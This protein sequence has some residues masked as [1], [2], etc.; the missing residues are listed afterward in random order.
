M[1]RLVCGLDFETTGLNPLEDR[2][3]EVGAVLWDWD[4]QCPIQIF[5]ELVASGYPITPGAEKIHGIREKD[6]QD[7]G[8]PS[9]VILRDLEGFIARADFVMAHNAPFD[10]AFRFNELKRIGVSPDLKKQVIDTL[11]DLP[12]DQDK[13]TSMRLPHLAASHGFLNPFP[14]RAV[15]DVLTMLKIA[16]QYSL[17]EILLRAKTPTVKV[18]AQVSFA[19]KDLAKDAGFKWDGVGKVWFRT[20]KK[21]DVKKDVWPFGVLVHE[22]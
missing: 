22:I 10:M 17:D 5:S 6:I 11:V 19:D 4:R 16:S 20:M 13:H 15:F 7:Y 21:T 1:S 9:A 8:V 14:H 12:I 3:I 2:V 18:V